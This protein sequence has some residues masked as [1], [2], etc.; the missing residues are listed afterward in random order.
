MTPRPTEVANRNFPP[1]ELQ[2]RETAGQSYSSAPVRA[3]SCELDAAPNG[4]GSQAGTANGSSLNAIQQLARLAVTTSY[5]RPQQIRYRLKA[6]LQRRLLHPLGRWE[7][8]YA[9]GAAAAQD[10]QILDFPD[11]RGE[12]VDIQSLADGEFTFLNRTVHLGRPVDWFPSS[13]VR[14]WLYNLHY[15]HY[16]TALGCSYEQENDPQGYD[17]FRGLVRDWIAAC[18]VATAT[19]WDA[20]PTS[21][22]LVNWIRAYRLFAPLLEK[23]EE[24]ATQLRRSLFIQT[25]FLERHLEY[26]LLNNHLLENGRAL[27]FAGMF[28]SGR[29][30]E[31]W[32]RTGETILLDGLEHDFLPDGGHDERSPMYHQAML[33]MYEEVA[34]VLEANGRAVP[35][36]LQDRLPE[37]RQWL[38]QVCHPDG[39]I[40][41]LNDA[42]FGVVRPASEALQGTARPRDGL[43]A[44]PASGYF[45][46]RNN[47]DF[48]IFDCGPLGPDHQP[49]HGHCDALSYE[50]S[51]AGRRMVVD[52][53]VSTYHG[54]LDWR[55]YY[56]STRAHNT[57]V[58][59]GAEQSEI[60]DR[61]R[62]ARRAQAID[63]RW[64]DRDP[65]LFYVS[66]AHS[67]YQRLPGNVVHRRWVCW[68][69]QRF[70]LVCDYVAG[71][72]NHKL[73]SFLHFHPDAVVMRTPT[74]PPDRRP[75]AVR[76]DGVLLQVA[77]FGEQSVTTQHGEGSP[78]QGW[79]APEFGV[80]EKNHV[81]GFCF[82]GML[83]S[84]MGY[85]LAPEDSALTVQSKLNVD[86]SFKVSVQAG[87]DSFVTCFNQ[88]DVIL[89]TPE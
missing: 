8:W 64:S 11:V 82:E 53:G 60:W 3:S 30:A 47:D 74:G 76:R 80:A 17:V 85:V 7:A 79:Y 33:E 89:E 87:R 6:L 49:G 69:A 26:D 31:R 22:R 40:A 66:G 52:S 62:V 43:C 5:L 50:L 19:A 37:L 58:V 13:E 78:I 51:I 83:P 77:P 18:P 70:W 1:G 75:G 81:W 9:R 84:W 14:L 68:V 45:T 34:A 65:N 12:A 29:A 48:L 28:F 61:F 38:S 35:P 42:A 46:I 72:G 56:R 32:H 73:E 15:W 24:F 71:Q 27:L 25:A 10:Y 57:L 16:A 55:T 20:Y 59:D 44:M 21:L 88:N 4:A 39:Q 2:R 41:L 23:D 67:G 36:L 54:E 86:G 63:P